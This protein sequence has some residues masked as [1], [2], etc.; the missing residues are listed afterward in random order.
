MKI[1]RS[2][3]LDENFRKLI[4]ELD[5]E[6]RYRYKKDQD[7]FDALN[8]LDKHAKVV[9]AYKGSHPV[10]CGCWRKM[11]D[12]DAVEIKRMYVQPSFRGRGIAAS[13]LEAL[14][15]W[16]LEENFKIAKLETGVKQPEAISLYKRVGY[17]R[18]P[19]FG[20]YKEIPDESICMEKKLA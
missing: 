4:V 1:I 10:G 11:K 3:P 18:I 20:A 14:E 13:I 8:V 7:K 16:A 6:L 19:N 2:T 15:A 17:E 5:N 12:E 9:V